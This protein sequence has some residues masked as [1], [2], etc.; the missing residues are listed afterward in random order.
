MTE[1]E[2]APLSPDPPGTPDLQQLDV[3]VP[4]SPRDTPTSQDITEETG[5]VQPPD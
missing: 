4:A 3:E 5:A 1:P 2:D